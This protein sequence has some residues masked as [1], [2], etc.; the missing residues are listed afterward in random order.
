MT[1][2][3]WDKTTFYFIVKDRNMLYC[4]VY[5]PCWELY[6]KGLIMAQT[7]YEVKSVVKEKFIQVLQVQ[8]AHNGH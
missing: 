6:F 8:M 5:T 3:S 2:H 1:E 4:Q 7:K